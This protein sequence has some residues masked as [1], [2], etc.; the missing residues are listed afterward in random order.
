MVYFQISTMIYI[1]YVT[2][3]LLQCC[4]FCPYIG[5]GI[6][7]PTSLSIL[8]LNHNL[9]ILC[10]IPLRP[11]LP[12]ITMESVGVYWKRTTFFNFQHPTTLRSFFFLLTPQL[13]LVVEQGGQEEE[14]N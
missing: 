12:Y 14:K 10:S 9:P 1:F 5:Y 6:L 11:Y 4:P 13:R 2:Q 8:F 7:L 3:S